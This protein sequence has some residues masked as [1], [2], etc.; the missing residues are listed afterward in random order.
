MK[1]NH[2]LYVFI[3]ILGAIIWSL[4][5]QETQKESTPLP[6]IEEEEWST[7][8]YP[9]TVYPQTDGSTPEFDNYDLFSIPEVELAITGSLLLGRSRYPYDWWLKQSTGV[10]IVIEGP[11]TN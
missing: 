4:A 3:L 10:W 9:Q 5:T 11:G 6:Q 7:V 8:Y 1:H 2:A